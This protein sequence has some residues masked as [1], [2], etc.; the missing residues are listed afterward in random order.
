MSAP[1][2]PQNIEAERS[3][4]G[5]MLLNPD[6]IGLAV[7]I[8]GDGDVF[9]VEAHQ[10]VYRAILSLVRESQPVDTV[11]LMER[12]NQ[13]GTLEAAGGWAYI[14]GMAGA[15]P[16]SANVEYY[17]RIVADAA[18]LRHLIAVTSKIAGDAYTP[19]QSAETIVS[20]AITEISNVA[21]RRDLRAIVSLFDGLDDA[22]ER[23]SCLLKTGATGGMLTGFKNLDSMMCGL[24]KSTLTVL[25]ARPGIGKTAFALSMAINAAQR[26]EEVLMFSLEMANTQLAERAVYSIGKLERDRVIK[27]L[28]TEDDVVRRIQ[29]AQ[30]SA[31]FS[32]IY[33][34]DNSRQTVLTLGAKLKR[35]IAK[36]PVSMVIIDYMQLISGTDPKRSRYEQVSEVS[37]ELKILAGEVNLPIVALAQLNREVADG[38][39]ELHHLRDS[40][41][42]E[43]DANNVLL[44]WP[45]QGNTIGCKI[46]KQRNGP[47][48][49][50]C[51]FF[52]RDTQTYRDSLDSFQVVKGAMKYVPSSAPEQ[53]YEEDDDVF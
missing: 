5:A 31:V 24:E 26:G 53:T 20:N 15:V 14:G 40:G 48:G 52:D 21:H 4:L 50:V 2:P 44:L 12:L 35:F 51:L 1:I 33:V 32:R 3:T 42:I 47:T 37:R 49:T 34:D 25:A 39:P 16:T 8:L 7:E 29:H 36:R 23:I 30:S 10:H 11:T 13:H 6:A 18:M 38:E 9:Y 28:I 22:I 45:L 19:K 27:K 41:T 46:A 43:Q 17:A